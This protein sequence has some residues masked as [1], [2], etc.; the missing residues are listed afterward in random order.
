MNA[1]ILIIEDDPVIRK[2]LRILLEGNGYHV[3]VIEDFTG[4][5]GQVKKL[6]PHL[7]LLDIRLP[8]ENGFTI[9]SEI[10]AFSQVPIVF[11]TSLDSDM[12]ELNSIM[13]GGDACS[14]KPDQTAILLA[15]IDSLLKRAYPGSRINA[16]A[17]VFFIHFCI[18]RHSL[19]WRRPTRLWRRRAPR[20]CS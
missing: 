20:C 7:I 15:K 17:A 11:V 13:R 6:Q 14:T 18:R 10:R 9:C 4:V 5:A 3:F 1:E 2:E 8:E 19:S 12:D 16:I